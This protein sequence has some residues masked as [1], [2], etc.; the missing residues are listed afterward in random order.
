MST[1][2]ILYCN[3]YIT[4]WHISAVLYCHIIPVRY[5]IGIDHKCALTSRLYYSHTDYTRGNYNIIIETRYS[6][7]LQPILA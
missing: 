7:F 4:I 1:G 2:T 3:L 6:Y 5:L